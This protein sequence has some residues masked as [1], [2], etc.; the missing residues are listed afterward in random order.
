MVWRQERERYKLCGDGLEV[1]FVARRRFDEGEGNAPDGTALEVLERV[2]PARNTTGKAATLRMLR[3]VAR[4]V[5][6]APSGSETCG[7]GKE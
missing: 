6:G 3:L 7:R 2:T 5:G 4:G 1:A